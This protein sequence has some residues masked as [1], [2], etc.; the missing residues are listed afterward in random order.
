VY[1]DFANVSSTNS[2]IYENIDSAQLRK[3]I[4]ERFETE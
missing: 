3:L 4:G 2:G 1:L